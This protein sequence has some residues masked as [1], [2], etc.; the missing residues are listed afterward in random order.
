M[1]AELIFREEKDTI[2][3]FSILNCN[4]IRSALTVKL[5]RLFVRHT[6]TELK[7]KSDKADLIFAVIFCRN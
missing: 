5:L 1:A 7:Q 4:R 3:H 6:K 2:P